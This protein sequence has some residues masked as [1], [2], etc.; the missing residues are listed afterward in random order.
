MLESLDPSLH[1]ITG[2]YVEQRKVSTFIKKANEEG[3]ETLINTLVDPNKKRG[4]Y[5]KGPR[6]EMI[7][8][9]LNPSGT[10]TAACERIALP[11]NSH[12]NMVNLLRE[13]M[14]LVTLMTTDHEATKRSTPGMPESF[15]EA[16]PSLM[17]LNDED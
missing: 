16:K 12:L 10:V 9:T 14:E 7:I 8:E 3:D 5:K 15:N 2:M 17:K 11:E 13:F 1:G 6:V 4:V